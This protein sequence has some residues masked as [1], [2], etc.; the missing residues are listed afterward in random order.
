MTI[1]QAVVNVLNRLHPGDTVLV[2]QIENLV[3]VELRRNYY[4]GC[5][6]QET[7]QRKYREV[8]DLCEM[9]TVPEGFRKR[10]P[11]KPMTEEEKAVKQQMLFS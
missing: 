10:M 2:Y 6:S 1:K 9:E 11:L 4:E 7:I 8:A 5:P 3:R